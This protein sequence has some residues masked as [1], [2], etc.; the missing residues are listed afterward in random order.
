[1][2]RLT[3]TQL[4][5]LSAASQREDRGVELPANVQGRAAGKI[6]NKL[7]RAA[8]LEEVGAPV[9]RSRSGD[10]MTTT[11]RLPFASQALASQPSLLRTR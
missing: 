8:L 5:V 2:A 3:D 1:M 7:I 9:A 11:E 4:V 6:V 10:A